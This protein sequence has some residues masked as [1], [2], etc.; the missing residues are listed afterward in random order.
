M[1]PSDATAHDPIFS[2]KRFVCGGLKPGQNREGQI[3][4]MSLV[5][6]GKVHLLAVSQLG[7]CNTEAK[8]VLLSN[9][10]PIIV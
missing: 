5:S 9:R 6:Q 4:L 7:T 2:E 10:L 3:L 1:A 8:E